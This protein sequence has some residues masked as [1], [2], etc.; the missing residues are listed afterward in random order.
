MDALGADGMSSDESSLDPHT[1]QTTYTV[2]KPGWRHPDLH[3]WLKIF[4]DLHNRNHINAVVLDKRGMF[5][6]IRTGSQKVR[7][8]QYAPPDLPVNAYDPD[9]LQSKTPLSLKH[10]LRPKE[11]QYNFNHSPE[12]IAYV[13]LSGQQSVSHL[14]T[15]TD[16]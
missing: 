5:T 9:W 8:A 4:D 2:V 7:S 13:L 11:Y 6:H 15:Y 16:S 3:H 10:E 12:V 14:I 1:G